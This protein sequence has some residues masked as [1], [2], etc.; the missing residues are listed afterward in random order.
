MRERFE[1]AV[2][3]DENAQSGLEQRKSRRISGKIRLFFLNRIKYERKCV[4]NEVTSFVTIK[5][6]V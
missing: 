2:E 3:F 4:K 1:E 6:V 5:M